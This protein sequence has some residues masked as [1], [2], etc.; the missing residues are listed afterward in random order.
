MIQYKCMIQHVSRDGR[1]LIS[2]FEMPCRIQCK[3][4]TLQT[5]LHILRGYILR[6]DC[7][8]HHFSVVP[9]SWQELMKHIDQLTKSGG[10]A[11]R[12]RKSGYPVTSWGDTDECVLTGCRITHSLF[13]TLLG[14]IDMCRGENKDTTPNHNQWCWNVDFISMQNTSAFLCKALYEFSG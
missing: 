7:F 11:Q 5:D 14:C 9:N 3:I 12:N 8:K 4:V 2:W 6:L 13:L 10:L 1:F